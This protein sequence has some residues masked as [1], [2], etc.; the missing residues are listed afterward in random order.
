M[1]KKAYLDAFEEFK[2]E[3][4]NYKRN[5][6]DSSYWDLAEWYAHNYHNNT[7]NMGLPQ[8]ATDFGYYIWN[9]VEDNLIK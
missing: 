4:P 2:K 7:E 3:Y 8:I 1:N 9:M 5:W 6:S